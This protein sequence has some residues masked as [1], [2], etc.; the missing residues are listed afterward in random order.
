MQYAIFEP[1]T[2][3]TGTSIAGKNVAN[4]VA[5]LNAS[6]DMLYHLGHKNHADAIKDSILKT[7]CEDKIQTPGKHSNWKAIRELNTAN[8]CSCIFVHS[9]SWR[10]SFIVR[11][12]SKHPEALI[13]KVN[14]LVN[15]ILH[16]SFVY[17][18]CTIYLILN[19]SHF[20]LWTLIWQFA[21]QKRNL[22]Q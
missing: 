20:S 1:G 19:G 15:R 7:I 5:M 10:Q 22:Y 4:P 6:V 3:N 12:H 2:R 18:S 21:K 9:R 13:R 11:R 16:N 17:A 8:A 14:S